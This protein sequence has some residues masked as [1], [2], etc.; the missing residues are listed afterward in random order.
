MVQ[1]VAHLEVS[2]VVLLLAVHQVVSPAL[3]AKM[4]PVSKKSTKGLFDLHSS[5]A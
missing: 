4:V 3:V 5:F 2:L 1:L